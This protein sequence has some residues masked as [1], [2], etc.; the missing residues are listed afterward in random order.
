MFGPIVQGERVM[1]APPEEEDVAVFTA[2]FAD[3]RVTRTLMHPF[4]RSIA[5]EKDWFEAAAA[6]HNRVVWKI[7][8]GEQAIGTTTLR[9]DWLNRQGMSGLLIGAVEEWGK[10][11]ATEAVRL[12]TTFAFGELGLERLGS[13][14]YGGNIGMH[15][16]LERSGYRAIGRKR[17]AAYSDGSWHDL[18]IFEL[19]R[20]EWELF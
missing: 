8:A 16:A 9:V 20:E 3:M 7:V 4:A 13:E 17:R 5:Q 18:I 2:W 12:R 11:Y 19:L 10:G 6:D 14:S 15:R 1:L